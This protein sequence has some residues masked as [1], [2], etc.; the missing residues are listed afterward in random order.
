MVRKP[1]VIH[2]DVA[3]G[4]T[5]DDVFL[6]GAPSIGHYPAKDLTDAVKFIVRNADAVAGHPALGDGDGFGGA[7]LYEG[8]VILGHHKLPSA[9]HQVESD[10]FTGVEGLLE[11][12]ERWLPGAHG[13]GPA[14][15]LV[16]LRLHGTHP[17]Y[18]FPGGGELRA[19][20]LLV[21]QALG[22]GIQ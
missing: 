6:G 15:A 14:H 17:A 12:F 3:L 19:D 21:Q 10:N 9:A 2:P 13:N 5:L 20:E 22:Y 4:H 16:V 8:P 7:E 18:H 1:M 11:R